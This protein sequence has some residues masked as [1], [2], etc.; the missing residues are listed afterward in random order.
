MRLSA[1]GTAAALA[2]LALAAGA[3]S[4]AAAPG[5]EIVAGGE[6]LSLDPAGLAAGADVPPTSYDVDG[7]PTTVS[8][9]SVRQAI[10]LAGA[11]PDSTSAVTVARGD[12]S[13]LLQLLAPQLAAQHPFAEGPA[14]VWV[15]DAGVTRLLRPAT[16]DEP[17]RIVSSDAGAPLRLELADTTLI[18]VG[19][20][21]SDDSVKVGERV[22][23]NSI[24][25]GGGAGGALSY[26]WDFDDETQ[27]RGKEVAHTFW[28]A[29]SY[30]VTVSVSDGNGGGG[31]ATVTLTVEGDGEPEGRDIR[32]GSGGGS[33]TGATS[34]GGG[35]GTAATVGGG[36]GGAGAGSGAGATTTGS[37]PAPAPSPPAKR[38]DPERERE[39]TPKPAEA[40]LPTVE[41]LLLASTAAPVAPVGAAAPAPAPR[42][43]ADDPSTLQ[44]PWVA[45]A[46]VAAFLSGLQLAR[47]S[48]RRW[49][50]AAR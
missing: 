18:A 32:G 14:V 45:L 23:F 25:S 28:E 39:P 11:S 30:R 9:T 40:A 49:A 41:G 29:G 42:V 4:A 8:G 1:R 34:G 38:R 17:A 31:S 2:G 47:R 48:R 24:A 3:P 20:F 50:P 44:V 10:V 36:A 33:G 43:V 46:V 5:L 6:T 37:T 12:G 27:A 7:A 35:A 15:D 13:P 21:S 22:H 16:D 19:A 26:V